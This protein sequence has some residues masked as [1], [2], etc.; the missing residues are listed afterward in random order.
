MPEHISFHAMGCEILAMVDAE[1]PE[2][3]REMLQQVPGW[4]EQWEQVLSRFR[5]D[6][7]L[8]R[9]NNQ[10]N[11]PVQVSE[12]LWEVFQAALWAERYT[13]GL[14]TPT[15]A[16]ALNLAGYDR[17]FE[18]LKSSPFEMAASGGASVPPFSGV[19]ADEAA[20]TLCLPEGFQLDFGGV[21]KGWAAHQTMLRLEV[22]GPALVDAGGDIAISDSLPGPEPWEVS[23]A[24]PL[25][26]GQEVTRL[27]LEDCG[28]ATSGRDRRYWRK[29]G[30]LRH[31]IIDPRTG[32]PAETD[33]MTATVIAPTVM[34]AEAAS[35]TVMILGSR[36]GIAWLQAAP[37][38]A[39]LFVLE[40]GQVLATEPMQ[41]YL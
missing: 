23:V 15:V 2:Q 32:E 4:F 7:E 35:K 9:L 22:L 31:H 10:H 1:G 14:V 3:A 30:Q 13:Q 17:S 21:A 28:V 33:L 27:Y 18:M 19:L 11:K 41:T 29:G 6:S 40:D 5:M 37:G 38:L 24:D 8:T 39:G 34:Q 16:E 25:H 26:P 20:R 12:V 36:E